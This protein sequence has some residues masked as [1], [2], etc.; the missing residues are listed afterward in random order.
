MVKDEV[1]PLL[2][3]GSDVGGSGTALRLQWQRSPRGL[4]ELADYAANE[5]RLQHEA[6]LRA[7]VSHHEEGRADNDGLLIKKR[8]DI[9]GEENVEEVLA[10]KGVIVNESS[11]TPFSS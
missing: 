2:G 1:Q 3:L 10:T 9:Q 4:V 8:M 5:G 6:E 7:I 11:N